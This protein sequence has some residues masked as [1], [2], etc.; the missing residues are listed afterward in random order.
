MFYE[1]TW[2]I[3]PAKIKSFGYLAGH[4]CIYISKDKSEWKGDDEN[5]VRF[6]LGKLNK[7]EGKNKM[8]EFAE[9]FP[10]SR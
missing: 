8:S 10:M 6:N 5:G 4:S 3:I 7:L 2:N 9:K 1:K